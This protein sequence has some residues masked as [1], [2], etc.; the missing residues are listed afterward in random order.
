MG[1]NAA[2]LHSFM[3]LSEQSANRTFALFRDLQMCPF[4]RNPYVIL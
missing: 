4:I 1:E 2:V 3:V